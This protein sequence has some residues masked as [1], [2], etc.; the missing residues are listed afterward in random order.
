MYTLS[1]EIKVRDIVSLADTMHCK[2]IHK[3][4]LDGKGDFGGGR[5]GGAKSRRIFQSPR[6]R[7]PV[8]PLPSYICDSRTEICHS[9]SH[10]SELDGALTYNSPII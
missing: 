10:L 2:D 5:G 8:P 4:I 3:N 7:E 9:S 6:T 1:L